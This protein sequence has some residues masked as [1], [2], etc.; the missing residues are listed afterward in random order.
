MTFGTLDSGGLVRLLQLS[1]PALP[2][3]AFA[4]SQGLETAVALGWIDGEE[5]SRNWLEGVLDEGLAKLDL[6]VLAR[7]HR[8]RLTGDD[9]SFHR[10]SEYLLASRESHE[11]RLEDEHLGRALARLLAD[12]GVPGASATQGDIA[13]PHAALFA[14]A[15]V[16]F[17][18]PR[19][20]T[21][22]GFAFS[23]AESQ[24]GALS[25]L[26]PLGQLAAQRVLTAVAH[27]IPNA[28]ARAE[29]LPD[30]DIGS[31]LPGLALASALHET[32]YCRL[33][34]S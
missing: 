20:E 1:S 29:A 2:V 30:S 24:V 25:R 31:C 28:V 4:F 3:G 6:P 21:L 18:I 13:L 12:R 15:A 10:W 19:A 7:L 34:K 16:D 8:S 11:R 5:S 26:V 23:W 32:Q 27:A 22:L 33:F 17:G 14:V 9:G